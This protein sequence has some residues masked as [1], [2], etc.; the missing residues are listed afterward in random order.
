MTN[1]L[2]WLWAI[3]AGI[4][5]LVALG[6]LLG[7]A[8]WFDAICH[9]L[10]CLSTGGYSTHDASIAYY[11]RQS[12]GRPWLI[13][14]VIIFGMFAGGTSF[15]VHFRLLQGEV[16]ALW[17]R[18]ETRAWLTIVFGALAFLMLERWVNGSFTTFGTE[19]RTELFTV[20]AIGTTTGYGTADIASPYFG[21]AARILFMV[22][23]CIGGCVGSTGGGFKVLRAVILM[24]LFGQQLR[25]VLRPRAARTQVRMD[26]ALLGDAEVSRVAGLGFAWLALLAVGGVVTAWV[27]GHD[28]YASLSGMFSAVNNIGPCYLTV[29]QLGDLHPITKMTYI[30]GMLAG[31]LEIIPLALLFT[32][33]AWRD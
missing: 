21:S 4:T 26:G 13:E 17:D 19:L 16:T 10:T 15:L 14:W 33:T 30:L 1:T 28:P 18:G 29:E 9:A 22:L 20:L 23:M 7:G 32:P 31:R 12:V 3:Y 6:L 8:G 24:K 11:Q 27:D 5:V 25:V 2:R